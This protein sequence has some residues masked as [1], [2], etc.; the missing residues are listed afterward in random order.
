MAFQRRK[1]VW[2]SPR[3]RSCNT[4][5]KSRPANVHCIFFLPTASKSARLQPYFVYTTISHTLQSSEIQIFES[6][7]LQHNISIPCGHFKPYLMLMIDWFCSKRFW[8]DLLHEEECNESPI[9]V[10]YI[11]LSNNSRGRTAPWTYQASGAFSIRGKMNNSGIV[12]HF[13]KLSIMHQ[14]YLMST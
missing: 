9:Y 3:S 5:L 7:V 10:M 14:W 12:P 6:S 1:D 8:E 4:V 11:A 2:W 13:S